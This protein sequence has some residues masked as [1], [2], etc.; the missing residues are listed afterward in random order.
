MLKR[1][2]MQGRPAA[3]QPILAWAFHDAI[4]KMQTALANVVDNFPN[5]AI[6]V[7]LAV[8]IFP[9]GRHEKQPGDR[10]GHKV[11]QLLLSPS[12]T[13]DRLTDGVFISSSSSNPIGLLEI[14]LPRVIATEPLERRISKAQ[15]AGELNSDNWQN[16]LEEAVS[17]SI[18]SNAEAE[19]LKVVRQMVT[20][21]I[22]VDE[23][24]SSVL[25]MGASG[26]VEPV[27]EQAA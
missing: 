15:A 27:A 11:A 6:R 21:I 22:A 13:R 7:L 25:R 17:K 20:E 9:L 24:E 4:Y 23:F 1:F 2:E 14:A 10:L 12:V 3:D 19:D 5:R 26:E 18:I 8:I 16:Q